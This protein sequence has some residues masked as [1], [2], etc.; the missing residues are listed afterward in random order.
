MH[1][2]FNGWFW[3]QPYV[4]SGQYT[5]RLIGALRKFDSALKLTLML[6]GGASADDV[7]DGVDVIHTRRVTGNLGKVWFEQRLYPAAVARSGAD[8]AH[9]PYWGAPLTSP[10]RLITSVLDVIP[11]ALPQY[12]PTLPAKLYTSLVTASA[13]GSAHL[14][15]I[16]QA[17]KDDILG[18]IGVPPGM[19][20]VTHLAGDDTYHPRL[21]AERDAAVR[22][23]Y[24]LPD[25]F[26]LCLS[27]FDVRKNLKQLIHAYTF[28]ALAEGDA[29]PLVIAGKEP[30][31]DDAMF[32]NL[33]TYAAELG[34]TDNLQW[35]GAVDEADKPSLYRLADVFVFP[36]LYEGFGLPVLEA[37]ACGTPVIAND[38]PVMNEIAGDAAYLVKAGDARSM[39]GAILALLGQAPLRETQISRGLGRVTNFSWRKTARETRAVYDQVMG[40]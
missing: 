39:G 8:I 29:I 14:I 22:A 34:L 13:R 21:G 30:V 24:G 28:V 17:A 23:K 31:W 35:I 11:L 33:R 6:P 20:T 27:G 7:P 2:A 4:G 3:N 37:M 19:V 9:V 26:V 10:A 38:I 36:T 40:M 5:R 16:S 1:I 18:Y 12:A 15:T 25:Q 32:P